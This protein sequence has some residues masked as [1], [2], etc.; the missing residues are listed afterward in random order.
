MGPIPLEVLPTDGLLQTVWLM[1][2]HLQL[3]SIVKMISLLL[4]THANIKLII[5]IKPLL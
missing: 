4:V 3:I 2:V 1:N 5:I